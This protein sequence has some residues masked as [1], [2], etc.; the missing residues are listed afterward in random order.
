LFI[1]QYQTRINSSLGVSSL[2]YISAWFP[3][4]IHNN[5]YQFVLSL[6]SMAKNTRMQSMQAAINK[7]IEQSKGYND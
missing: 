2:M 5:T 3:F 1:L 6:S 7:L 4:A